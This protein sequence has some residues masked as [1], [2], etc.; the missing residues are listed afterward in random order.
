VIARGY[1][2]CAVTLITFKNRGL[3][4]TKIFVRTFP[5][6]TLS[7]IPPCYPFL[8]KQNMKIERSHKRL[9]CNLLFIFLPF[10][11][12]LLRVSAVKVTNLVTHS[13]R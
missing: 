3:H 6:V 5:D 4:L 11:S 10:R 8:K 13:N 7:V 1:N 12:A 9:L 2:D